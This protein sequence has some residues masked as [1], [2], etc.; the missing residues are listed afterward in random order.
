MYQKE[1]SRP[2]SLTFAVT[3]WNH[4]GLAGKGTTAIPN[5]METEPFLSVA[6][7]QVFRN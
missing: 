1:T 3:S 5:H 6:T 7:T 2:I 4:I